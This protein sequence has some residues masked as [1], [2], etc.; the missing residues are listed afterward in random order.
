[1]K[2]KFLNQDD[3]SPAPVK[4]PKSKFPDIDRALQVWVDNRQKKGE[5]INDAAIRERARQ[6]AISVGNEEL[7]R[8]VNSS[9][10]LE[11]FK[12]K[13]N[14]GGSK[15]K[16]LGS[17][18]PS[19]SGT[20]NT[21]PASSSHTPSGVSP[22]SPLRSGIAS[23]PMSPRSVNPVGKNDNSDSFFSF[24]E[25]E[26]GD[27]GF[28]DTLPTLTNSAASPTSSFWPESSAP[29]AFSPAISS[30]ERLQM[31]GGPPA[32]RP[33]SQTFPNLSVEP[34]ALLNASHSEEITPKYSDRAMSFDLFESPLEESPVSVNPMVT[35]K[36]NNS[37]PNVKAETRLM[38]PP[39]V[40][41]LPKFDDHSP[42]SPSQD[43]ARKA[44]E[45]VM[46]FFQNQP[47]ISVDPQDFVSI[48]RLME[49]LKLV[50]SPSTGPLPGGFHPVSAEEDEHE[51][52]RMRKKRS[53][54]SM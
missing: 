43:D 37:A 7:Q 26:R 14:I 32:L 12:S 4:K 11:R 13:H 30:S 21:S 23:P 36:R 44:L 3:G 41:P 31:P 5:P 48:G 24:D 33:R 35:M 38:Q 47:G 50:R 10:W 17:N 45:V 18:E 22:V 40:P 51:S 29:E 2:D 39:P 15:D 27:H 52:P 1:M 49:K 19:A 20:A 42:V 9:S 53:I 54:R 16:P 8:K 34:G 46:T 25:R 6:F 28:S